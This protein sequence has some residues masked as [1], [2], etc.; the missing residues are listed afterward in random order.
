MTAAP[1]KLLCTQCAEL[2]VRACV[3]TIRAYKVCVVYMASTCHAIILLAKR[4]GIIYIFICRR[5]ASEW[6]ISCFVTTRF[7]LNTLFVCAHSLCVWPYGRKCAVNELRWQ[8]SIFL[9]SFRMINVSCAC[10]IWSSTSSF[11]LSFVRLRIS[12]HGCELSSL[13]HAPP[14]TLYW[15]ITWQ[16]EDWRRRK[17]E[18]MNKYKTK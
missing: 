2:S 3:P 8:F 6:S 10:A 4:S 18:K 15:D 13:L 7:Y 14:Y 1:T 5:A 11:I 12:M 17:R 16:T 9:F